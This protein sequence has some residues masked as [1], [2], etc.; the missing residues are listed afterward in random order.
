MS[1][2]PIRVTNGIACNDLCSLFWIFSNH[3][4]EA[5]YQHMIS[6][7][8]HVERVPDGIACPSNSETLKNKFSQQVFK[9]IN[10]LCKLIIILSMIFK[11]A[12]N[13]YKSKYRSRLSY[14]NIIFRLA[15]FQPT[16][17]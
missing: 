9:L 12:T 13:W 6:N 4:T 1:N 2:L 14:W 17:E 7:G 16:S 11:H 15:S 3:A 8:K 10:Q 5:D